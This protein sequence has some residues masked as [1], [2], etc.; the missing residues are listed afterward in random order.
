MSQNPLGKMVL[1]P[2]GYDPGVL[3][4]IQRPAA[5]CHV[6]GYERWRCY[7]FSWLNP[8]GL[9]RVGVL[10]FICP[11]PSL[12]IVESKSLKLYLVGIAN[13][14]FDSQSQVK[15][16]IR[17]DLMDIMRPEW[18]VLDILCSSDLGVNHAFGQCIDDA[19]I[20]CPRYTR[21]PSLLK[22]QLKTHRK[23]TR[24]ILYSDLLKTLCP[25]TGQPDW[26]TLV[27]DYCGEQIDHD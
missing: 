4:A 17:R 22:T 20:Q 14:R 2:K 5:P 23:E 3:F 11:V 9:P 27:I 1:P 7:E 26:A 12:N 10:E 19:D 16:T 25:I 15:E 24:E 21:D 13:T 8:R 6:Y 18:F